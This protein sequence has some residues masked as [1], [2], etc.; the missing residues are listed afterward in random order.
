M[1]LPFEPRG[2]GGYRDLYRLA[3]TVTAFQEAYQYWP[4]TLIAS[5]PY[6]VELFEKIP[7]DW[8]KPL[9]QRLHIEV[10]QEADVLTLA[11]AEGRRMDYHAAASQREAQVGCDWLFT[12]P[13]QVT[14]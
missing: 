1:Q 12:P 8:Q 11:D 7:K 5:R 2:T 10:A 14:F 6:L 13:V 4:A 9:L 3:L